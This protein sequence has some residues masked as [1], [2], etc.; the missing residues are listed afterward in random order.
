MLEMSYVPLKEDRDVIRGP[1]N[2]PNQKKNDVWRF[3]FR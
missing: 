2:K 1:L 3:G